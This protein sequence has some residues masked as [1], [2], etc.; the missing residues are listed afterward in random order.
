MQ[1][2]GWAAMSH[3]KEGGTNVGRVGGREKLNEN[4]KRSNQTGRKR[5]RRKT[6]RKRRK[7]KKYRIWYHMTENSLLRRHVWAT[8]RSN[9]I[10]KRSG[11]RITE[12]GLGENGYTMITTGRKLITW[13]AHVGT[14]IPLDH[15]IYLP[16][17]L[18]TFLSSYHPSGAHFHIVLL[19][20]RLEHAT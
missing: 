11:R 17:N 7:R 1:P 10:R 4:M 20:E 14:S 13:K 18:P 9:Q 5:G 19:L 6:Q 15:Y 3:D 8:V 16:T 2:R 12:K